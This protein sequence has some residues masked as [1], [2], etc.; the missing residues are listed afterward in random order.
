MHLFFPFIVNE[1]GI[2]HQ[3]ITLRD[4]D[5]S[6][7]AYSG[8]PETR[9]RYVSVL[10]AWLY[11]NDGSNTRLHCYFSWFPGYSWTITYCQRCHSHLGWKFHLVRSTAATEDRP[12]FFFGWSASSVT[13]R[14]S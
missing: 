3:T 14:S 7:L 6:K 13:F 2:I 4:A 12:E 11:E 1:Y 9:D 8:G 5:E 10:A